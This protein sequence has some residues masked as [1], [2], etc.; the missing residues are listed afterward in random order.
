MAVNEISESMF[1]LKATCSSSDQSMD[2][3]TSRHTVSV[4]ADGDCFINFDKAVT[5][6]GRFLIKAN[7][8]YSFEL[9]GG[10]RKLHYLADSSTPA[11]YV[12]ANKEW[13]S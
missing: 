5:S 8:H 10:V 9:P 1:T 4:V 11:V 3:L 12:M 2:L 7:I 13:R 6:T